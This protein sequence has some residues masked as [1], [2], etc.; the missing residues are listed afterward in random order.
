MDLLLLTPPSK[1][2]RLEPLTA[3]ARGGSTLECG[4]NYRYMVGSVA[5]YFFGHDLAKNAIQCMQLA[6]MARVSLRQKDI[7]LLRFL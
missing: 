2:K 6:R 3:T 5:E 1:R 7:K 4:I